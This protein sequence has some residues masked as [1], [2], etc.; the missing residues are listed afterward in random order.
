MAVPSTNQFC[1]KCGR[2]VW[3]TFAPERERWSAGKTAAAVIVILFG[4][5][6][7]LGIFLS[8]FK[9]TS[10]AST[11][12]PHGWQVRVERSPMDDSKTVVLSLESEG[13]I[14]GPL[15]AVRPDLILRCKEGKTA[16]Y[17]LTGMAAS[18]DRDFDDTHLDSHRVRT[19]IDDGAAS[20]QQWGESTDHK[21]LFA[22]DSVYDA[23]GRVHSYSG[24]AILLARQL[25]E[26]QTF[27]FEFTPF[28]GSPQVARF[29]I[30]GLD[31]HLPKLAEACG[32]AI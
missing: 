26:A 19:R 24:G 32:W 5:L 3:S 18:V 21:A 27:T 25:R 4:C 28:D 9:P 2:P 20:Y 6:I 17:V 23:V 31:A 14:Q 30:R 16:V 15:G 11:P 29:D 8:A 12:S 10:T 22:D 1:G 13:L 7:L